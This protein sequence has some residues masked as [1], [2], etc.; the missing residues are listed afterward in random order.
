MERGQRI[1]LLPEPLTVLR[2]V[3]EPVDH[4]SI[5]AAVLVHFA[6]PF[7]VEDVRVA[8]EITEVLHDDEGFRVELPTDLRALR[9]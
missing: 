8:S 6:Y 9:D 7:L 5:R 3:H 1:G 4:V 2:R